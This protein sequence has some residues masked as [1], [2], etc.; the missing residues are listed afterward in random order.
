[1]VIA[2]MCTAGDLVIGA[3]YIPGG[4]QL[5]EVFMKSNR[6]L[7]QQ[8]PGRPARLHPHRRSQRSGRR[9]QWRRV[10]HV[11]RPVPGRS[12]GAVTKYGEN[13]T[14]N[15]IIL[16]RDD[17]TLFVTNGPALAAFDVQPDG[18]LTNRRE[19]AKWE[20]SIKRPCMP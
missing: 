17:K 13:L 10:L 12:K 2:K 11:W 9:R 1:M 5:P 15:G 3:C 19:F 6:T 18:S 14:I 16:S 20:V 8:V 7:R 4:R